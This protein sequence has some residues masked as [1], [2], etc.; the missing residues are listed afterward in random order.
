MRN[1]VYSTFDEADRLL[2]IPPPPEGIIET[3]VR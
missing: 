1:K 3:V 2:R